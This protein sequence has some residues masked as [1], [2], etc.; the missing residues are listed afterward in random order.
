LTLSVVEELK[1][2]G[3]PVEMELMEGKTREECLDIKSRCHISCDLNSTGTC[4]PMVIESMAAGHAV[5]CGISNFASSYHPDNPILYVTEEN[6]H[7]RLEYLLNNK[8]EIIRA[9][10]AGKTWARSNHDPMKIIGQYVW[11][12][13]LVMNGHRLVD[14]RDKYLIR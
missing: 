2:E 4:S 12:Y 1:R 7:D 11:I 14:D 9:G 6:L 10:N 5:L 8:R 13:D 3:Y